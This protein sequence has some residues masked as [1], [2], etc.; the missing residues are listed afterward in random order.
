MTHLP[1][2]KKISKMP[3]C[4]KQL[5]YEIFISKKMSFRARRRP[6]QANKAFTQTVT[7]TSHPPLLVISLSAEALGEERYCAK[8]Y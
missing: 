1:C 4:D 5:L 2:T 7:D 6:R 8:Q 3:L